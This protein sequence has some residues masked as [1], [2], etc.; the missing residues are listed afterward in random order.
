MK[1]LIRAIKYFFYFAVLCTLIVSA[2]VFTGMTGSNI[3]DIFADGYNSLWQIAVFFMIVAAIYPKFGFYT[4]HIPTD[5]SWEDICDAAKSYLGDSRYVPEET[6]GA[7]ATF[8]LR[9]TAGKL[10]KMYE[11]RLTITRTPDGFTM[12]GLRKDVMRF[13]AGLSYRLGPKEE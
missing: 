11:D 2:L 7:H 8:R 5:K 10:T 9:S 4:I 3:E 12:E 13:S 6:D 1:Y